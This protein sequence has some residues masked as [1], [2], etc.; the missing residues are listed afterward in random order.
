[1]NFVR[2]DGSVFMV[3]NLNLYEDSDYSGLKK[4]PV[5]YNYKIS[6]R[7]TILPTVDYSN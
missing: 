1:M 7:H 6:Q 2:K 5:K 4:V 3:R